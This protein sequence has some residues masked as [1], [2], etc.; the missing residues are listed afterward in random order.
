MSLTEGLSTLLSG[1]LGAAIAAGVFGI[2]QYK[3]QRA[4]RRSEA[5]ETERK[6]LRYLMLYI[7]EERCKEHIEAGEI[8]LDELRRLH[9]WHELYH[10]GLGGN[11]D[12]DQLMKKVE[13]LRLDTEN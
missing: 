6:A 8:S 5:R 3:L 13:A 1:G 9:H 7:I 11:G 2:I 12:A 4:D 10:D